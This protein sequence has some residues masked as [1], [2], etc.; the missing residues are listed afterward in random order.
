ML[1]LSQHLQPSTKTRRA[2][3]FLS[4]EY[5]ALDEPTCR[6]RQKWDRV[7]TRAEI[8]PVSLPLSMWIVR[9]RNLFYVADKINRSAIRCKSVLIRFASGTTSCSLGS[10][11]VAIV[12]FLEISDL[13]LELQHFLQCCNINLQWL[14]LFIITTFC[15][16]LSFVL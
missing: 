14:L 9:I 7:I 15:P 8:R 6:R 16:F 10:F 12:W 13:V 3:R 11:S 5:R 2:C 1:L 4:S